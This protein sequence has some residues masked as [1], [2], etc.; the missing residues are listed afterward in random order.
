MAP[1]RKAGGEEH[2]LAGLAAGEDLADLEEREVG[3]AAGLVAGGGAQEARQQVG[4]EVAHLGAD[5]VLEAHRLGGAAEERGGVAVDEAVGDALV[6]AE[7]GDAAAGLALAA[8]HRREDRPG[9]AGG[10]GERLAFELRERGDAG[11]LLDEV[12][13]ALDV[14]APGGRRDGE[15]GGDGEAE[16]GEDADLLGLG[17]LHADEADDA[18]RVEPVAAGRLRH[19]AGDLDLGGLAAAEVEDHGRGELHADGA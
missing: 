6:E 10:A 18:G 15:V 11:D 12:G 1:T 13:L 16:G 5:R 19:G 8:L 7:G 9:D 4:A 17:D 2:L 3:E 14:R